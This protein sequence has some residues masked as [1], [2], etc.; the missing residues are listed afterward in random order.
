[1][2]AKRNSIPFQAVRQAGPPQRGFTLV[3]IMLAL[4]VFGMITLLFGA[5]FPVA[6]RAGH[7]SGNYAEA[8]M[9]GQRKIDQCRQ[10]GYSNLYGAGIS[11]MT[12]LGIIDNPQPT[13]Y[14]LV[15]GTTT[16]YTFTQVDKLVT[17][18]TVNGYFQAGATG[19]LSIGPVPSGAGWTA[20]TA[21]QAVLIKTVIQWSGGPQGSGL[22]NSS[23]LI[24]NY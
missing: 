22:Y 10:A 12:A 8:A 6:S 21:S 16:T 11:K 14:P 19:T 3:E 7:L 15:N 5:I 13:G 4:F 20:P 1:M 9:I 2:Y 23:A 18:G 24:R 17:V